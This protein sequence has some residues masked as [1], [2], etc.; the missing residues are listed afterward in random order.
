M[1]YA[2]FAEHLDLETFEGDFRVVLLKQL[3]P[4]Q[5]EA[6]S[7]GVH[8][9]KRRET[10]QNVRNRPCFAACLHGELG[11]NVWRYGCVQGF[12]W[13]PSGQSIL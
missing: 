1:A 11:K 2:P 6:W 12:V 7:P 13:R 5:P 10:A 9:I 8:E 3:V 4:L